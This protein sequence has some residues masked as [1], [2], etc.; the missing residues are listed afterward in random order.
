MKP[1]EYDSAEI[2]RR[3]AARD[4]KHVHE[5]ATHFAEL[6]AADAQCMLG[7]LYQLGLGVAQDGAKA[8]FWFEE[9]ARQGH[10]LALNNLGTIYVNGMPGI[11]ADREKALEYYLRAYSAG[12]DAMDLSGLKSSH[13]SLFP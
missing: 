10:A 6:R 3:F 7:V 12:F 8:V 5:T 11:S 4:Y 9:A 1:K 13:G 2:V